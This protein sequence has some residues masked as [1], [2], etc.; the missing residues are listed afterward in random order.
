MKT[1][2]FSLLFT[3]SYS[4]NKETLHRSPYECSGYACLTE[5]YEPDS[6]SSNSNA[7]PSAASPGDYIPHS[8]NSG[9]S[10]TTNDRTNS[11]ETANSANQTFFNTGNSASDSPSATRTTSQPSSD[12]L[13]GSNGV[14]G[15][16]VSDQGDSDG[17]N[18]QDDVQGDVAGTSVQGDTSGTN[19]QGDVA[20]TSI[21]QNAGDQGRSESAVEATDGSG[22][23]TVTRSK[24]PSAPLPSYT[25]ISSR[26]NSAVGFESN[27]LFVVFIGFL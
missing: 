13:S 17:T 2:I 14:R 21:A 9:N 19:V 23:K 24:P 5:N 16:G 20:G 8:A 25:T 7:A 1:I 15:V 12:F 6:E 4:F 22:Q 11:A 26:F 18:V 10:A 3:L 27:F